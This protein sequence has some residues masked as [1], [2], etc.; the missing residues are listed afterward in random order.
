MGP[1]EQRG[2]AN[3]KAAPR[4]SNPTAAARACDISNERKLRLVYRVLTKAAFAAERAIP[5]EVIPAAGR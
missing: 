1:F 2:C 5:P 4:C 3:R